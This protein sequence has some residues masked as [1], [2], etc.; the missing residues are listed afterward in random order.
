MISYVEIEVQS[1]G[2][3][4]ERSRDRPDS[5][6]PLCGLF[7][8]LNICEKRKELQHW[9]YDQCTCTWVKVTGQTDISFTLEMVNCS[10]GVICQS[11]GFYI[12]F[13]SAPR[14]NAHRSK[15]LLHET[16]HHIC[17]HCLS[18]VTQKEWSERAWFYHYNPGAVGSPGNCT[19]PGK[20]TVH[21][22]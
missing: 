2:T 1:K 17:G 21:A 5:F 22:N 16:K 11:L 15:V 4:G 6:R 14:V 20:G 12:Y 19:F 9:N 8:L 13:S 3:G 10:Y 7:L 18:C